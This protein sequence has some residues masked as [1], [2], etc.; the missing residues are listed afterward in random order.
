[1]R[2]STSAQHFCREV[3]LQPY[4]RSSENAYQSS[5]PSIHT[6]LH[7]S[8]GSAW[9]QA[10]I[11][12]ERPCRPR[13][14]AQRRPFTPAESANRSPYIVVYQQPLRPVSALL[15]AACEPQRSLNETT[16]NRS[17]T[18]AADISSAN[19][20]RQPCHPTKTSDWRI[21]RRLIRCRRTRLLSS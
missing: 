12:Q 20:A 13:S 4:Y 16:T 21:I 2:R 7:L 11:D 1:M 5:P 18:I 10:H 19:I 3:L 15:L 17:D 9:R 8:D 14:L 6:S